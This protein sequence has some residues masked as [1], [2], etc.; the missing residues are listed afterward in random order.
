MKK[1]RKGKAYIC[2]ES[3]TLSKIVFRQR[4]RMLVD[5]KNHGPTMIFPEYAKR[6]SF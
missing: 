6:E 4:L 5:L 1:E 3:Q 2:I